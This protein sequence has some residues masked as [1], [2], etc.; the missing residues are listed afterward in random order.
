[1]NKCLLQWSQMEIQGLVPNEWTYNAKVKVHSSVGNFDAA[2]DTVQQM[3]AHGV[4]PGKGTWDVIVSMAE[5]MERPD[6]VQQVELRIL[7]SRNKLNL[8]PCA[9]LINQSAS[10]Q[11]GPCL[12]KNVQTE[13]QLIHMSEFLIRGKV[14]NAARLFH[15]SNYD[16]CVSR[17][18]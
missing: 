11:T 13:T 8:V 3:Q 9:G 15:C 2:L 18:C 5:L 16:A 10:N 14:C 1:M 17:L 6:I 7:Y 4:M 12:Q